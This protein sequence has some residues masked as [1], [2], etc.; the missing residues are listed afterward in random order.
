ILL[1][2]FAARPPLLPSSLFSVGAAVAGYHQVNVEICLSKLKLR[3]LLKKRLK[4]CIAVVFEMAISARSE[5]KKE[6]ILNHEIE[7]EIAYLS[8]TAIVMAY[9]DC[10]GL[11]SFQALIKYENMTIKVY[12]F[13]NVFPGRTWLGC[14]LIHIEF[15]RTTFITAMVRL[16]DKMAS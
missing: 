10:D 12:A 13:I 11:S 6:E 4:S 7:S 2:L 15:K 1:T 16:K 3:T 5:A 9:P 14:R 8:F